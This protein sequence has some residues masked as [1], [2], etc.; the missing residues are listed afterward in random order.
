MRP[1]QRG[2]LPMQNVKLIDYQ[3]V[4]QN[5]VEMWYTKYINKL[6]QNCINLHIQM[7]PW[8]LWKLALAQV[9]E[10][11]KQSI[12]TIIRT[13]TFPKSK[14]SFSF[15][16]TSGEYRLSGQKKKITA[17]QSEPVSTQFLQP[18][19]TRI[20]DCL[21]LYIQYGLSITLGYTK[22]G[23]ESSIFFWLDSFLS[24]FHIK[25]SWFLNLWQ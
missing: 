13:F 9:I 4:T 23:L 11:L 21:Y 8:R 10:K 20:G 17:T 5:V 19:T 14:V 18:I 25:A 3:W 15:G 2:Y 12:S 7:L 1:E 16:F 6:L 22:Q 24:S